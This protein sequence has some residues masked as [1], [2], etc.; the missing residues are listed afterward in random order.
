MADELVI[1]PA[2]VSWERRAIQELRDEIGDRIAVEPASGMGSLN[3]RA[4]AHGS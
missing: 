2:H 4:P 1:K 3:R